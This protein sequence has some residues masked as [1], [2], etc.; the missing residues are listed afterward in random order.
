LHRAHP[1]LFGRCFHLVSI[2]TG[3]R[4]LLLATK[5]AERVALH[6]IDVAHESDESNMRD[7]LRLLGNPYASL[8]V[9]D[10][11][12]EP[13]A[14]ER[15]PAGSPAAASPGLASAPTV[16]LADTRHGNPYASLAELEGEEESHA[17]L[18]HKAAGK[19]SK[20]AFVAGCRRIFA[21]YIPHLEGGRLRPEHRD[22]ITRNSLRSPN[23][24]FRLLQ[25]IIAVRS[26]RP[27]WDAAA[28]QQGR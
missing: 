14:T 12:D 6:Y 13:P 27:P 15:S 21:P 16:R 1:R 24:R 4:Q 20:A 11:P 9:R 3:R 18:A 19:L 7:Y 25:E 23:I 17:E 26:L 28:V 10:V 8:Q 22:F 2:T 5:V